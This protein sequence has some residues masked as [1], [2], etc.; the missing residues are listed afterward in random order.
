MSTPI[1]IPARVAV[2]LASVAFV[3]CW[4]SG[5]LGAR[6]GSH[7][8][9]PVTLLVWRF[10]PLLALLLAL[11]ALR[12][13]RSGRRLEPGEVTTHLLVGLLSQVGYVLPVYL[14]IGAGVASGTTALIDAVQPLVVATLVGPLLGLRVVA[15][16]WLGLAAGAVGVVLVV[17][18]DL[19]A[20]SA[21]A[22]AYTLPLA[23]MAS[24]VAATFVARR[25]PTTTSPLTAL[26][27]HAAVGVVVIGGIALATGT[28]APPAQASFWGVALFLAVVPSL[29]G[30]GLY[31]ALLARI[32]VTRLN[33]LLFLVAPTTAVA[34]ALLFGEPFTLGTAAGL[35][36]SGVAVALVL[37]HEQ[38]R[39]EPVQL[40]RGRGAGTAAADPAWAREPSR[41]ERLPAS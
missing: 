19:A 26:T 35:L 3:L 34:G 25:R 4:S 1:G 14:A 39:T 20:A 12:R 37:A 40:G 33:A 9:H 10:V 27:L 18:A 15:M 36:L 24:L 31:W 13:R 8:A 28:A 21:P 16:Q 11:G 7:D 6:L 23:A 2:P 17:G 41:A 38:E 29:G 22:W 32:G 30:Y 5:F